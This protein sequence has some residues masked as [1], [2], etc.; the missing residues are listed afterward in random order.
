MSPLSGTARPA[1]ILVVEDEERLADGI[2]ENLAAEG[3][4]PEIVHDGATGLERILSGGFD[5]VV[6]DVM[7]PELDGFEVCRQARERGSI[8]PILF[9]TAKGGSDDRIR[10]LEAGGDDYMEKPF[11]L[12]ELLLRVQVILRRWDWYQ[13]NGVRQRI[14]RFGDNEFDPTT[15]EGR[16][17]DGA[18]HSLTQKEALIL[19]ALD[20]RAGAVVSREDLLEKVWG[21]DVYPST[22]TIDNFILRLRKRFEPDPESPRYFHTVRGVGYRFTPEGRRDDL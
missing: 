8:V 6:L 20:E 10:G 16:S 22:R 21:Y 11:R 5:L 15:F 19:R 14:L 18:S 17:W 12:R 2:A 3:Y 13:G 1:R 7:L 9:L 4:E